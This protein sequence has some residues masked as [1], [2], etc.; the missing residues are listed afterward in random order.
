MFITVGVFD[1]VHLGHLKILKRL[2]ELSELSKCSSKIY[3]ILYP[4]EY[5][6]GKFDGLIT[7]VED[8]IELLSIYGKTEILELPKIK[9]LPPEE[10]FENITHNVK[11]IV[12]GHDFRF[13]KGGTGD[14]NLL[15]HLARK[16]GIFIEV[17][18]PLKVE[19]IR[20]SSSYIRKLIKNGEVS[21]VKEFLGRN[22]STHGFVYKD[23]QIGRKLGFPT[24]NIKRPDAFLI[25]PKPGVYLTKVYVP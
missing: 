20:I 12:V 17:V 19:G 11:G 24:A 1:G 5:Y 16:R 6:F 9:D 21:K 10:F 22:Y 15:E 18:E 4:M 23:R 13:G 8:R 25:D 7:S 3:T 2:T 14:V